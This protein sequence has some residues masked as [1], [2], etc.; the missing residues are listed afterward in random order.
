[1]TGT[2]LKQWA[3]EQNIKGHVKIADFAAELGISRTTAYGLFRRGELDKFTL[4]ALA[5]FGVKPAK[6]EFNKAS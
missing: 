5:H 3:I 2:Q 4:R 6:A 1:M